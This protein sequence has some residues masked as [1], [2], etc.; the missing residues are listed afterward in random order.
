MTAQPLTVFFKDIDKEDIPSVGGKGANLG[1]MT[2]AGFPVPPGFAITVHSYQKFIDFNGISTKINELLK[3]VDI[4]DPEQLDMA[5]KKIQQIVNRSKIPDDVASE[6]INSYKKLSGNFKQALVA[7][8]SSATAEDLPGASFAGQ[9]ATFLNI[10]GYN[11]LLVAVRECWASLF[12]ARAIFYRALNKINNEKVKISVIIQNMIQSEASGVMFSIDPVTNEKDKIIIEAI[13]GLGEYIVQG[14]VMPDKYVVQKETFLI[15]SKEISEQKIALVRKGLITEEVKVPKNMTS[16]Q[17]ISDEDIIELAKISDKLQKHYYFPQ[18]TEW[19]K[20]SKKGGSLIRKEKNKLFIVQTRPVTTVG[21][22]NKKKDETMITSSTPI[23]IGTPASPGIG[24]GPAKV[25]RSPKE[26]EKVK[27]RDILVAKMTSP[28]YVPAM[29]KASAIITDEGGLTSHAAIVSRELGVPCVVGTKN[30]TQLIKEDE[31]VTV[32]GTKG[33]IYEGSKIAKEISVKPQK[34][35]KYKKIRSATKIY[36]NLAE[37]ERAKEI[38]KYNV[39]GVGLLRAEFMIANIGIHP[40][41]AIKQKKQKHFIEKLASDI[42]IFCRD[43]NPRPVV[44]R[45]TDFKTNEYR[46]LPGGEAWEPKEANPMLG[47]RGAFRYVTNPD[48]FNLELQA[49]KIVRKKYKN[50]WLMIPF[51]RSPEE[52]MRVR[53]IVASEGLFESPTFKFWMMVEIP[54][55]VILIDE[56]I[57]V[58]IDGVSIGSN[59]LTMLITGTDRDNAEVAESFNERSPAVLWSLRRVIKHCN[60]AKITSSIC[61]QAPSTYEDFVAKMIKYGITS[62]S[63]NPDAVDR[64]RSVVSNL[65][66][67]L[68]TGR[69]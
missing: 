18:D 8:R 5:S 45:A 55:N 35:V 68:V 54:I 65:E 69:R 57:Q 30:A 28:D 1:E 15:L 20:I 67:E 16:R 22:I 9:Q 37:P 32:D 27:N 40:K 60:R 44:Y 51:V 50:L 33:Y 48:V 14:S 38:S 29:R 47:F 63:I 39:D 26:I 19:A 43:F 17:K 3:Q 53:R 7:V 58:G 64:V 36:V 12:T 46:S 34:Q 52:L 42:E 4:D 56:F 25:L 13:W 62:L 21:E 66:K 41:E 59:D 31:V 61:G 11:N 24:T 49:I 23:L 6:T 2:R 10:K